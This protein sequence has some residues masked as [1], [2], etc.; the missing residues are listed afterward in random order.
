TGQER[1]IQ[2]SIFGAMTSV[3][4]CSTCGGTGK[5]VKDPCQTCNGKGRVR[6]AKKFEVNIPKGIDNGQTIRLS[7]KGEVGVNGGGYGDLMLTVYIKAHEYFVRKGMDI[8]CDVPITFV[9]AALGD[10][11]TVKT[12]Y[13]EQKYTVKAGTQPETVAI[14]RE[15][16]VP[17]L[18]N[19]K[20]RGNQIMTL[21]VKIPTD[22]TSRQKDLLKEFYSDGSGTETKKKGFFEKLMGIE[23]D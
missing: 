10:E 16:G 7:G 20:Q 13:G 4:T 2:Q 3:R 8:Y 19:S 21:K 6:K 14:I 15:A 22:M 1:V 9:Q 11:I 5:T 12:V 18:R 17:T 23:E